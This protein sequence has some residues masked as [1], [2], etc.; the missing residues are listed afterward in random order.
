[1]TKIPIFGPCLFY[2]SP[3]F[4]I[5]IVIVIIMRETWPQLSMYL[6]VVICT[7]KNPFNPSMASK[8]KRDIGLLGLVI[9]LILLTDQ[10]YLYLTWMFKSN[11]SRYHFNIQVDKTVMYVSY[12]SYDM[13]S[14]AILYKTNTAYLCPHAQCNKAYGLR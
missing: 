14:L 13:Q 8:I 4:D 1:M 10:R 9:R 11:E 2:D 7:P 6:L 12:V 5:V 3:G